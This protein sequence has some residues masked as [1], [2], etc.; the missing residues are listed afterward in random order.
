[1]NNAEALQR[2]LT[3]LFRDIDVDGSGHITVD[4]LEETL[5]EKKS[6]AYLRSLGIDAVD[7]WTLVKLL[8]V[9]ETGSVDLKEFISGCMCLKGEARAV[10]IATL[11]YDQRQMCIALEEFMDSVDAKLADLVKASRSSGISKEGATS[12]APRQRS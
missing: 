9:D 3:Q 5:Q 2:K 4:E 6:Q 12:S 11:A 7:A 10:H 8:D 1:M